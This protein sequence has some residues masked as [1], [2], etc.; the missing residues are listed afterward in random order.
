LRDNVH[1]RKRPDSYKCHYLLLPNIHFDKYL[2]RYQYLLV[3]A[4]LGTGR[5]R[6]YE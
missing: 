2:Y 6:Y 1:Y 4:S 5:S 3:N